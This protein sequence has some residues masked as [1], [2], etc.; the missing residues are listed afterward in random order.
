M[1]LSDAGLA[2]LGRRLAVPTYDRSAVR[3]G[4]VHLGVGGFHRAHQAAYLDDLLH[5][6]HR[7]WGVRGI[8]ILP[9]DAPLRDALAAQ[10]RLYTH[11]T[12]G[13]HGAWSARV[14]GAHVE[15]LIA[16]EDPEAVLAALTAPTTHLVTMTITE[17]GYSTDKTT[18]AF[19]PSGDVQRDLDALQRAGGP[20]PTPSSAFG[21]LVEALRRRRAGG[22]APFTVASCDNVLANGDVT[23][24]ALTAFAERLDPALAAWLAREV[25]FPSSMVDGITPATTD[26]DRSELLRRTGVEDAW[27]VVS[28]AH[29]QWVLQDAFSSERPPLEE[30]GVEVVN[31]VEGHEQVKLRLL[32]AGHQVLAHLGLLLGFRYIHE[33]VTDADLSALLVR[34][35]EREAGPSVVPPPS[36]DLAAYRASLLSRFA[37]AQVA[38]TVARNAA[39]GSDRLAT[40][41]LPVIR[42]RLAVGADASAAVLAVA[43]WARCAEGVDE[44]GRPLRVVDSRSSELAPALAR[45]RQDPA[46]LL[47][48]SVFGDL[49][50]DLRFR[51]AY[52]RA[53]TALHHDGA[54]A[55]IRAALHGWPNAAGAG[56]TAERP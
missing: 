49:S 9:S 15:H 28:E 23:R 56:Q 29:R 12:K 20:A 11:V 40:F 51:Q 35:L 25:A 44:Q 10:D 19:T 5:L 47:A 38:D 8:G 7:A 22:L 37:N 52:T 33:A 45:Q 21:F 32:N 48:T 41:V 4:V 30:V 42:D 50:A 26:E 14:V 6:G 27:P 46:A 54:R 55:A 53:L 43:A 39:E 34:Y 13:G 36:V 16:P 2:D 3:G 24:R 1:R 31:D 18:G 17:G